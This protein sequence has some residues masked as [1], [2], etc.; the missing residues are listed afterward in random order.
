MYFPKFF[1]M[2]WGARTR[3]EIGKQAVLWVIVMIQA[4]D[5]GGFQCTLQRWQGVPRF[6][7]T[8]TVQAAEFAGIFNMDWE[9]MRTK[10]DESKCFSLTG[11]ME[12]P[13]TEM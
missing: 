10:N 4:R 13:V 5:D 8:L 7:Y 6:W 12:L 11:R 3:K 2:D 1:R 9:R